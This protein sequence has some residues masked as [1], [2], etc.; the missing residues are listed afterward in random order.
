MDK[1][2]YFGHFYFYVVLFLAHH[3]PPPVTDRSRT[4]RYLDLGG[5]GEDAVVRIFQTLLFE[6]LCL[7]ANEQVEVCRQV[8]SQQGFVGRNVEQKGERFHVEA[9]L[10]H[11]QTTQVF[12]MSW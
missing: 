6:P 12:D 3:I 2:F 1:K 5:G 7:R 10:Q 8:A 4:G 9:G 11:L